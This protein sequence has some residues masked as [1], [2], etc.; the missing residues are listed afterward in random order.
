[1]QE[2]SFIP[3][4]R[5]LAKHNADFI[6]VGGLSAVLNGVAIDTLDADIVHLR[7]PEN[8]ERTLAAL[9]EMD[10]YYRFRTDTKIS[11]GV[12]HLSS[13]GHQLLR[14]IHGALD[15]LG[16]IGD[17]LNYEDLVPH[18]SWLDIGDGVQVRI[19]NLDKYVELKEQLNREKDRAVLPILRATLAAMNK[20]KTE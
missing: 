12:S 15:V 10:A 13:K 17:G 6:L 20:G 5:T 11:P 3:I 16:S 9:R 7:S 4:L 8:V 18:S 19:L 2:G 1:M 14:T